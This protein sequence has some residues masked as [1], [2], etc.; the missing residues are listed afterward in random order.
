MAQLISQNFS[1]ATA[2]DEPPLSSCGNF[3]RIIMR[4]QPAS[5]SRPNLSFR[6]KRGISLS[7]I[8]QPAERFLAS[9]GMTE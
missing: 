9:L 6:A 3:L 7:F 5:S 8:D 4:H 2:A 1:T